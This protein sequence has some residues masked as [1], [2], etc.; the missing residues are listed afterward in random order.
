VTLTNGQQTLTV[1]GSIVLTTPPLTAATTAASTAATS[2]TSAG[3][4]TVTIITGPGSPSSSTSSQN[5]TAAIA[6][7]TV[8]GVALLI[9]LLLAL[10]L[11]SRYRKLRAA[12]YQLQ[13]QQQPRADTSFAVPS[14]AMET[15][16]PISPINT[17]VVP[18]KLPRK[19]VGKGRAELAENIT[20]ASILTAE[21]IEANES[22]VQGHTIWTAP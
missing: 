9:S 5:Q 17:V 20:S 10:Y 2:P 8:G 18:A 7:G 13:Q 22:R 15:V 4:V 3:P 21:E 11:W 1:A 14:P 16:S 19:L 6:G 12:S